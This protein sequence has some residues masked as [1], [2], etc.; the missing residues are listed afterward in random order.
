MPYPISTTDTYIEINIGGR[1]VHIDYADLPGNTPTQ[2]ANA[3][4]L[5]LQAEIDVR[6]L[7][8]DLPDD[9]PTKTVN[10]DSP[11][12]FWGRANGSIHANPNRNDHLIARDTVVTDVVWDGT[13]YVVTQVRVP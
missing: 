2:L 1:G 8:V 9:E 6:I 11:N 5:L 4:K 3:L 7:L 13:R 10:P 12:F